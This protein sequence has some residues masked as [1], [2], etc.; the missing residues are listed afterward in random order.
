MTMFDLG[1]YGAELRNDVLLGSEYLLSSEYFRPLTHSRRWFVAPAFVGDN[2]PL[3][4]YS[5][6]GLIAEYRN[7]TVGGRGDIGYQTERSIEIR[8]GY[9]AANQRLYPNVGDPTIYPRVDGREGNTHLR[10]TL[11]R[12]DHPITPM[13]GYRLHWRTEWWDGKPAA[14]TTFPLAELSMIGFRPITGKSSVY[15]GASGGSTLW[16]N[17]GGLPPFSLG[18]SFRLPAYNTNELLTNQY[19]LFQGGYLRKLGAL[20]PL[21]GGKVLL[22]AGADIS[23]AYY[24]ERESHLPSDGSAGL[25]I[26]TLFGPVVVGGAIGDAGH[27]KFFFEVGRAYF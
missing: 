6:D 12:L 20:S 8:F 3:N 24:V 17:P 5:A 16:E 22:F 18:G 26:N 13:S 15:L 7:R 2:S 9:E 25:I 14:G 27:Y 11:D 4:I 10:F 21:A 19:F 1:R 23:K